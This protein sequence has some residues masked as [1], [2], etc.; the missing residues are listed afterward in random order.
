[1]AFILISCRLKKY[2]SEPGDKVNIYLVFIIILFILA[3]SDLVVGVANDAVNFLNSSIGSKAAPVKIILL[4]AALGVF[5]GTTF[6]GGMMEIARSGIFNPGEFYFSE[7]M[8]IFLAV[9]ITDVVLLDSFNTFGLPT[10]TTV[11]LVFE[12]LGAA[13]ALSV[14]KISQAVDPAVSMDT[15]IN[16]GKALAIISGILISVAIAFTV[17]TVVQF[18]TR[19]IFSF[20]YERYMK[21]AGGIYGGGALTVIIYFLLVK[22]ARGASFHDTGNISWIEENT[23]KILVYC[24][25]MLYSYS[26]GSHI[27]FQDQRT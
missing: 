2:Y 26:S 4:I 13:V 27:S 22:G 20:S 18:F 6:S 19:L 24:L 11:S 21:Y 7:I 8:I 10:S 1:M 14:I 23:W 25:C 16:S 9:M 15:F 5:I 12:L 3:I 17:G